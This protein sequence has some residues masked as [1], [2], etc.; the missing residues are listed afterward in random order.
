MGLT[1]VISVAARSDLAAFRFIPCS[2]FGP[3]SG[4]ESSPARLMCRHAKG[5]RAPIGGGKHE[6]ER[7]T[8]ADQVNASMGTGGR[9][10]GPCRP[11]KLTGEGAVALHVGTMMA[12]VGVRGRGYEFSSHHRRRGGPQPAVRASMARDTVDGNKRSDSLLKG[13]STQSDALAG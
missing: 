7:R 12:S 10:R 3:A 8:C 4:R 1:D 6:G 11:R 5:Q 2:E 9:R 13:A